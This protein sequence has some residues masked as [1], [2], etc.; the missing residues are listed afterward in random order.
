MYFRANFYPEKRCW[1]SC[2]EIKSGSAFRAYAGGPRLSEA[3]RTVFILA[4]QED[5]PRFESHRSNLSERE[6]VGY[7]DSFSFGE[8]GIRTHVGL[9]PN[10]FQ[11]RLVMT[12]SIPL[13]AIF[14]FQL[15]FRPR[16]HGRAV[17]KTAPLPAAAAYDRFDTS[18]CSVKSNVYHTITTNNCQHRSSNNLRIRGRYYYCPNQRKDVI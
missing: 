5:S 8:D 10:G 18:P 13:R 11:D 17:F 1:F 9:P 16:P 12:T 14:Y 7:A 3:R 15:T 6:R 2:L 4:K